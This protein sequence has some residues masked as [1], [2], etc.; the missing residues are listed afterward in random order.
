MSEK[1]LFWALGDYEFFVVY[2]DQRREFCGFFSRELDSTEGWNLNCI[3]ILPPYRR[4]G[5]GKLLIDLSKQR[6]QVSVL[7]TRRLLEV[8][9]G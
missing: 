9:D 1:T 7:F 6:C 5:L 3:V 8:F 4:S 2:E